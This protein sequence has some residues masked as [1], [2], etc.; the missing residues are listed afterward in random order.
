VNQG[1]ND[2]DATL[3]NV[4]VF[5]SYITLSNIS[6]SEF[7]VKKLLQNVDTSKAC[8][9]DG[10]GNPLLKAS[11]NN[12]A[13]SFSRFINQ[14]LSMGFSLRSGNWQML[15]LFL[16]KTIVNQK[17]TIVQFHCCH[18][19]LK[20]VKKLFSSDL[21]SIGNGGTRPLRPIENGSK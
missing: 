11:A 4:E 18:H 15:Y 5:Q 3:S 7:E 12:I 8:G 2:T 14:S 9:A 20:F 16:K 6:T 17:R 13:C 1:L 21:S 10:V 19:Y